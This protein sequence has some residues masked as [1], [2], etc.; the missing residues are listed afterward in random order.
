[1]E[2]QNSNVIENKPKPTKG[3]FDSRMQIRQQHK[4]V[5]PNKNDEATTLRV[6]SGCSRAGRNCPMAH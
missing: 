4:A 3:M 1:M 5:V 6:Q 2:I